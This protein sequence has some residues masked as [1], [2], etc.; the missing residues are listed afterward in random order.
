VQEEVD[1]H[2]HLRQQ[3]VQRKSDGKKVVC[4]AK[5]GLSFQFTSGGYAKY[6]INDNKAL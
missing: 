5:G 1:L 2:I 3:E 6:V 4:F